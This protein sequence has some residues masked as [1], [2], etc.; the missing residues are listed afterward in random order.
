MM[1]SE[2]KDSQETDTQPRQQLHWTIYTQNEMK[3]NMRA[4]LRLN[5]LYSR[6]QNSLASAKMCI[7]LM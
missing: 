4:I 7:S 1:K 3:P 6:S 2:S 5:F